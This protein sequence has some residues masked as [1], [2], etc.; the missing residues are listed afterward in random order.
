[1]SSNFFSFI[2]VSHGHFEDIC[3][4]IKSIDEFWADKC[5]LIIID[6]KN[7]SYFIEES[8]N[9][10]CK[11]K[12]LN[13]R[14]FK[15]F[16]YK[17]FSANNNLGVANAIYDNIFIINPDIKFFNSDFLINMEVEKLIK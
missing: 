9:G 12:Y 16:N 14:V 15:Q 4:L 11:N 17:S 3:N 5:E 6:N 1:M 7:Q 8:L 10:I 13:I 2:T